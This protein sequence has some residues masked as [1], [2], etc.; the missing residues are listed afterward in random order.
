MKF[1][2]IIPVHNRKE[3]LQQCLN[4]IVEQEYPQGEY[5]IIIVDD[6]SEQNLRPVAEKF[7]SNYIKLT[8]GPNGPAIARNA[9]VKKA[10]GLYLAFTDSDC[11]VPSDW[12]QQFEDGYNKHPEVAGVGGY[13]QASEETLKTNVFAK[14]EAWNEM[15][16]FPELKDWQPQGLQLHLSPYLSRKRDEHPFQTNNISYKKS[17]FEEVGGFDQSFPHYASGEDGNLKEKVVKAGYSLL[18]IPVKVTHHQDYSFLTFWKRQQTRGAGILKYRTDHGLQQRGKLEIGLRTGLAPVV[19]IKALQRSLRAGYDP[20]ATVMM[21]GLA[22]LAY[23]A[24]QIGKL[25]HFDKI[26]AINNE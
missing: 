10:Q 12:L 22:K 7:A 17:V 1:S 19:F 20:A 6:D 11:T 5:E 21:A 23:I 2:V 9:G 16:Y 15:Q 24:R 14:Y 8:N 4:S 26:K 18:F 13:L 25:K 3:K